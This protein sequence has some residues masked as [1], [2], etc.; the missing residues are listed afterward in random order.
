MSETGPQA[1][2]AAF[3]TEAPL[4]GGSLAVEGETSGGIRWQVGLSVQRYRDGGRPT[5]GLQAGIE[6][7]LYTGR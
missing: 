4:N 1:I 6:L 7:P 2:N 5:T 3:G